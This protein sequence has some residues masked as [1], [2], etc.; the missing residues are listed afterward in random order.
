MESVPELSFKDAEALIE[1][2]K[3]DTSEW[4]TYSKRSESERLA[5]GLVI[6]QKVLKG[7]TM[8]DIEAET[9]IPLATAQRY[10]ERALMS[11]QLPTVDAARQ[12]ELARLD[13]IIKAVWPMVETGDKDAIASYMKVSERRAK[14]LGLDRP[15]QIDQTVTEVSAQEMELKQLLAQAE[16]DALVEAATLAEKV[17]DRTA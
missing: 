7:K 16:R 5:L 3:L 12:E 9:G 1:Q 15:I 2:L 10:K 6:L 4:R 8:R 17:V 13:A 14:L 11:V